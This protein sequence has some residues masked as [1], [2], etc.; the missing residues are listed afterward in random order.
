MLGRPFDVDG[1][2]WEGSQG[3]LAEGEDVGGSSRRA[4]TDSTVIASNVPTHN[5]WHFA[6]KGEGGELL[7]STRNVKV[8]R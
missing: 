5:M 1:F 8:Y 2:L 6:L 7:S 4:R 3:S